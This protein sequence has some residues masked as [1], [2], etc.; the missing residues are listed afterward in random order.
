MSKKI[1]SLLILL[2][3]MV[4]V[5]AGCVSFSNKSN[6]TSGPA[7]VFVSSDRGET[8]LASMNLQTPEGIKSI[9][10]V[11]V[12][13][14]V[15]DPH[16][17]EAMYLAS[18]E[19]GLFFTYDGGKTWQQQAAPLNTGFIYGVAVHPQNKCIIYA[20]NGR[21]LFKTDDCS[22]HWTEIYR[23]SRADVL[24]TSVA[25]NNFMPFAVYLGES[26]G[27]LLQSLDG[28]QS[29]NVLI[30]LGTRLVTVSPSHLQ[31]G[32]IY[33]ISRDNGIYR[34]LDN[35]ASWFS[36]KDKMKDFS[37]ATAYRRHLLSATDPDTIYW[38]S[39]YGILVSR[40]K[41]DS[42]QKFNLITPP[43]G[44]DIYAFALNP[45]NEK[46]IYYTATINNRSTFYKSLDGGVNWIT[47]KLPSGQMP[48]A[49]RV[50]PQ[51]DLIYLGFSIPP[52][53]K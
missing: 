22:R 32:L 28:G 8:W 31:S 24:I 46:E 9:S 18:R 51:K 38:V 10:G 4:L 2:L 3:V 33:V 43:G 14:I 36:L 12:Y 1:Y 53:T 13:R 50:H 27:D 19:N 15:E 40:D 39:T 29:W 26:N 30:R 45:Q 11:N 25:F 52:S 49:L 17:P 5:G 35:G 48:V 7:G 20:T 37:G 6:T 23:E 16:D 47:K 42:W 21:Q 44:A 34:T 41:G